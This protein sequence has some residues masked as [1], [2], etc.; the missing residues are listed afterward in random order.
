MPGTGPVPEPAPLARPGS[1]CS[2]FPRKVS[3]LDK[4]W[5]KAASITVGEVSLSPR[6]IY[7]HVA[8]LSR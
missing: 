7:T 6:S 1:R 8:G 5:A 3:A 2:D 4:E